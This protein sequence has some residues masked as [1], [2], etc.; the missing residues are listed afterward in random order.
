MKNGNQNQEMKNQNMKN[1]NGAEQNGAKQNVPEVF[2]Y[3][4]QPVLCLNPTDRFTFSFGKAKAKMI[5]ANFEQI[6]KFAES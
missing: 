6:K 5:V 1:Q 3:K 4:G 2:E